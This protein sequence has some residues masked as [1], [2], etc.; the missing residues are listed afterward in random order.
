[1]ND[2][3]IYAQ[4]LRTYNHLDTRLITGALD[5]DD[6]D[7]LVRNMEERLGVNTW[8]VERWTAAAEE[9]A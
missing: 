2:R 7:R 9:G 3:N 8:S 4:W 5:P 1:M 6:F